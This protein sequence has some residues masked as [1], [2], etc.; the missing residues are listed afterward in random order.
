MS[1]PEPLWSLHSGYGQ[2]GYD[3]PVFLLRV[4][5]ANDSLEFST[6]SCYDRHLDPGRDG[7]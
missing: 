2:A 5:P 6:M 1:D 3:E 4:V 7:E